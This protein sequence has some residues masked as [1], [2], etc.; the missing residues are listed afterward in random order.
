MNTNPKT[1]REGKEGGEQ[2]KQNSKADWAKAPG[3]TME[4]FLRPTTSHKG[5]NSLNLV[6]TLLTDYN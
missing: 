5:N 4:T 6:L 3:H 2:S 1:G